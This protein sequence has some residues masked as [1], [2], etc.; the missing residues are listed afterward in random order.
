MHILD[1]IHAVNG[2]T[3]QIFEEALDVMFLFV[4]VQ[5]VFFDQFLDEIHSHSFKH[6]AN[7]IFIKAETDI[8]W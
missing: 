6:V 3:N 1:G 8:S 5:I 7:G 2:H 4:I